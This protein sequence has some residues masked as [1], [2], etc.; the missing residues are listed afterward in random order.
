MLHIRKGNDFEALLANLI[1]F[2]FWEGENLISSPVMKDG[3]RRQISYSNA[4]WIC[5][6][7]NSQQ[8]R[9]IVLCACFWISGK[10]EKKS[11]LMSKEKILNVTNE[12]QTCINRS[13]KTIYIHQINLNSNI[14]WK[15]RFY[16]NKFLF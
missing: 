15:L 1:K 8:Y 4:F 13:F 10:N 11:K 7:S 14:S 16:A 9:W 3:W 5:Q 6:V 12:S 2:D